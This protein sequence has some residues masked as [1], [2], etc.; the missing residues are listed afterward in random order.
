MFTPCLLDDFSLVSNGIYVRKLGRYE[1]LLSKA[2][3]N[4]ITFN[5]VSNCLVNEEIELVGVDFV[6]MVCLIVYSLN[7]CSGQI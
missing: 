1:D 5:A 4:S 7:A 2:S 6:H 3:K